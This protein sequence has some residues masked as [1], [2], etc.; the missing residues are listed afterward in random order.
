MVRADNN[1]IYRFAAKN[2]YFVRIFKNNLLRKSAFLYPIFLGEVYFLYPKMYTSIISDAWNFL[3][4]HFFT[5][6]NFFYSIKI[7]TSKLFIFNANII[8]LRLNIFYAKIFLR[9]SFLNKKLGTRPSN[10]LLIKPKRHLQIGA[11]E[12]CR[13]RT[14]PTLKKCWTTVILRWQLRKEHFLINVV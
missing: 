12:C 7:F 11:M 4:P 3:T 2:A 10:R 9:P 5:A 8:F 6:G 1:V 14:V 13:K